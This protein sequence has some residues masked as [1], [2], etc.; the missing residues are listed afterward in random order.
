MLS[1]RVLSEGL[2]L[3]GIFISD[4]DSEIECSLSKLANDTK[5]NG[6]TEGWNAIERHLDGLEK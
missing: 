1:F 6:T 5:L 2:V 3:F 4:V